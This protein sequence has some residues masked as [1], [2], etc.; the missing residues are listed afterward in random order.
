MNWKSIIL[1]L[2]NRGFTQAEIAALCGC[3][4]AS[5]SDMATGKT[6]DPSHM[7]G[8]TLLQVHRRKCKPKQAAAPASIG[9]AATEIGA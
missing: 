5:I 2:Q 1:D 7:L 9:S 6:R 3:S 8:E 4:Q